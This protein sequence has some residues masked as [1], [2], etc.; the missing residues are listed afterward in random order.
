MLG[1]LSPQRARK[2]PERQFGGHL[3]KGK[4]KDRE[5][6]LCAIPR[7]VLRLGDNTGSIRVVRGS[8]RGGIRSSRAIYIS[9]AVVILLGAGEDLVDVKMIMEHTKLHIC[10]SKDLLLKFVLFKSMTSNIQNLGRIDIISEDQ[11]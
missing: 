9:Q 2:R 8:G 10:G 6:V 5:K 11:I 4:L 3:K 7:V 1:W